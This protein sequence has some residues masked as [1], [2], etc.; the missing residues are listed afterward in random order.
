M[1]IWRMRMACWIPKATNTH[2]QYITLIP[3]PL[4]YW[5][6]ERAYMLRCT[7]IVCLVLCVIVHPCFYGC[8]SWSLTLKEE[9]SLKMYESRALRKISGP[10]GV[11]MT[12]E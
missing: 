8:G 10:K 7:Y 11:K 12:G 6:H 4:Q 5:L 9:N 3:F 2:S 1:T